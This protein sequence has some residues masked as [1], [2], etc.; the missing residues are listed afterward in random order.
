M[1]GS[2]PTGDRQF[3]FTVCIKYGGLK[4]AGGKALGD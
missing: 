3:F 2:I 4:E 1:I